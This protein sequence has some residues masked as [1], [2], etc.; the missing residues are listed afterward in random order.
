MASAAA[1][2][3]TVEN[4]AGVDQPTTMPLIVVPLVA[5]N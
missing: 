2:A 5:P 3:V 1:I 4:Q